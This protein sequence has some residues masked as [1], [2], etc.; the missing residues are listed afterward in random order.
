MLCII[1]VMAALAQSSEIFGSAIFGCMIQMSYR[2]NNFYHLPMAIVHYRMVLTSAE[3]TSVVCSLQN[4]LAYLIPILRIS[5]LVFWFDWH[6]FYY[7]CLPLGL[8]M[9]YRSLQP[10]FLSSMNGK[11]SCSIIWISAWSCSWVAPSMLKRVG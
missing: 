9:R 10:S 7:F 2:K 1:S 6:G 3:L 5:S 11:R 4:L 8:T